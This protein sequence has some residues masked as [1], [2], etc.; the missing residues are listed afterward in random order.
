MLTISTVS[1]SA[2]YQWDTSKL[3]KHGKMFFEGGLHEYH[4]RKALGV[5][6]AIG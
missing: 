2:I 5:T 1:T 4:T 3:S 6:R